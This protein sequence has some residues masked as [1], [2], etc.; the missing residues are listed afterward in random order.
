MSTTETEFDPEDYEGVQPK[1]ATLPRSQVRA[2]EK[3]AKEADALREK[4]AQFERQ[5]ALLKAGIPDE[6]PGRLFHKA[7]DG[8]IDDIAAIRAAAIEYKVIEGSAPTPGEVA[9]HQAAVAAATGAAVPGQVKGPDF[10]KARSAADVARIAHE[11]GLQVE[12]QMQQR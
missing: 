10:S 1:M 4:V 5:T 9:G 6:G 7:Y 2:L 11:F 3:R 12:P 8:P